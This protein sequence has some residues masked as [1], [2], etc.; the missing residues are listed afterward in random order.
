MLWATSVVVKMLRRYHACWKSVSSMTDGS[1]EFLQRL[2]CAFH[3]AIPKG[4]FKAAM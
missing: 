2:H 1:V 4:E 3:D